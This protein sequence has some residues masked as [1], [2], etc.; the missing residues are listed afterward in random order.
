M[1]VPSMPQSF[2]VRQPCRIPIPL[3]FS[4]G[5]KSR[6]RVLPLLPSKYRS[7]NCSSH[8]PTSSSSSN[9]FPIH[10]RDGPYN[11]MRIER[12]VSY[13]IYVNNSAVRLIPTQSAAYAIEIC[14]SP[15]MMAVAP[16]YKYPIMYDNNVHTKPSPS[17]PLHL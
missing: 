16:P 11:T 4:I 2:K 17:S 3:L 12:R 5:Q 14:L 10:T 8:G 15:A 13:R 6:T 9:G 7:F 1:P